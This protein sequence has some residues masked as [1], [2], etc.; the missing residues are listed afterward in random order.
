MGG[1]GASSG[2]SKDGK[3]YGTEYKSIIKAGNIKFL[4]PRD[5]K[6][7]KTPIETMTKGRVYV[8]V[9]PKYNQPASITYYD[10]N[11]KRN[12]QIDLNHVHDGKKPHVHV[13]Y[14]HDEY[15]TRN[16]TSKEKRLV[17]SVM[18][19]WYHRGNQA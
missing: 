16:L 13:G 17:D 2:I 15:G 11:S 5:N 1:R 14:F 18:K 9:N 10:T 7:A 12:R 4:V 19:I 3:K 6:S 8:L